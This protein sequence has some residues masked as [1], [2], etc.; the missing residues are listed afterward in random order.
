MSIAVTLPDSLV[1]VADIYKK[2]KEECPDI[3]WKA[4]FATMGRFD[5]VDIVETEDSTQIEKAAMI[6]QAYGH[7]T[8]ETLTG[9][10]WE[11]FLEGL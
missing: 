3:T 9:T 5:V 4:S 6:I 10:P 7:S 11:D 8:T 2:I 1:S